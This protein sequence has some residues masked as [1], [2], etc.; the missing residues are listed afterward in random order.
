MK[1]S[2][3]LSIQCL[4]SFP[5]IHNKTD[6]LCITFTGDNCL[7]QRFSTYVPGPFLGVESSFHMGHERPLK[8]TDVYI[9]IHNSRK[10]QFMK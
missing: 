3:S 8:N 6:R 9:I 10:L 7:G 2:L 4:R 5:Q 1:I